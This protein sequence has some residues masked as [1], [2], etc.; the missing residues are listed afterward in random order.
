[1]IIR[2]SLSVVIVVISVAFVGLRSS[3]GQSAARIVP[4]DDISSMTYSDWV[5]GAIS[6]LSGDDERGQKDAANQLGTALV[7]APVR[8]AVLAALEP[9]LN[10]NDKDFRKSCV[11]AYGH[12]ATAAQEQQLLQVVA[13]PAHPPT[14]SGDEP[15]W[16]AAVSALLSLDPKAAQ[17]AAAYR[18]DAFFFRDAMGPILFAWAADSGPEQPVAYQILKALDP[19]NDGVQLS[20]SDA[21][22]LLQS[23]A[24]SDRIRAA[25][26][27]ACVPIDP[28]ERADVMAALRPHLMGSNGGPRLAFVSAFAHWA[29]A[30]D[31]PTLQAIIAYPQS[32]TGLTGHED[33][34]A[35]ATAGLARLDVSAAADAV[36]S[37]SSYFL[38]RV[39]VHKC[40]EPI[41]HGCGPASQTAGWLINLVES[42]NNQPPLPPDFNA[43]SA[44][45]SAPA[46]PAVAPQ[47][48][49]SPPA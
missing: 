46:S 15:C 14:M 38:Y 7:Y 25:K 24:A 3:L 40:L 45:P 12:W 20:I 9:H 41:A 22:P 30:Q 13:T 5:N 26:S 1:M 4:C 39:D 37:R 28:S 43:P 35:A 32:V 48:G 11:I 21:L 42:G 47:G 44:S 34:W 31:V 49:Q 17:G 36:R 23:D 2:R 27:L 18:A 19:S 33:C 8:A 6:N 10:S 29:T 16:A